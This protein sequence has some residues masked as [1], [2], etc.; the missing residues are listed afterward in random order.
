MNRSLRCSA[1]S[2]RFVSSNSFAFFY[3]SYNYLVS[4]YYALIVPLF[5]IFIKSYK[6]FFLK[7]L[8]SCDSIAVSDY[9]AKLAVLCSSHWELFSSYSSIHYEARFLVDTLYLQIRGEARDITGNIHDM[10]FDSMNYEKT[11]HPTFN[12]LIH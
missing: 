12:L 9:H 3:Y 4:L 11:A 1:R 10:G 6:A 2:F 5:N 8:N 7:I